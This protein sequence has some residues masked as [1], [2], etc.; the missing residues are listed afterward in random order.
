MESKATRAEERIRELAARQF[1]LATFWQ[2]SS[3]V[4]SEVVPHYWVP[5]WYTLDPASHLITSHFHEGLTEYPDAWLEAE[6][7]DDDV[8]QILDVVRS[9]SGISTLHE[10]TGGDPSGTARWQ[11]NI[12]LGGDQE[13]LLRLRTRSGE[14]WGALGLYRELD[15]PMFSAA[16]KQFLSAVSTP[17]AEGARRALVFGEASD[18]DWPD[19]PG[20]V[21]VGIDG[22]VESMT[23]AGA[24]WLTAL[25]DV[26]VERA[27]PVSVLAV[28]RAAA[29][30]R[31][32]EARVR[33]PEGPWLALSA[34]L[35]V[36]EHRVAVLVEPARPPRIFDLV[37][38]AHGLTRREREVVQLVL[39]GHPTA[40]ISSTLSVSGYTVQEHLKSV[41]EKMGVRSR[42]ELVAQA[43]FAHYSPRFRD[44]E[45]RSEASQPMRGNP[46]PPAAG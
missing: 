7:L 11:A 28:A 3:S 8:N 23:A 36:G 19:G 20:L 21:L 37:M 32:A 2:E 29:S 39:E 43:F 38:S 31:P 10:L 13:L 16:E 30:G 27:T 41:F 14:V 4:I 45:R 33:V 26:D 25:G 22:H 18:P 34:A 15:R 6:Y 35:L 42:R 44:N 46:A 5:C 1:D 12:E 17:L 24:A 40:G 9:D